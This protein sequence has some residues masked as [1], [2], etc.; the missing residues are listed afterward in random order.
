MEATYNDDQESV[1]LLLQYGAD[2]N[3][4]TCEVNNEPQ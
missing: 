3:I 2:P 1:T 4:F